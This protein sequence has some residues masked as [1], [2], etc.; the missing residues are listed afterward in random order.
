MKYFIDTEFDGYKGDLISMALIREDGEARYWV[1]QNVDIKNEWVLEH[2]EPH[3]FK[4][5]YEL[6]ASQA[7]LSREIARFMK[8][9]EDITILADWPDD[10]K[11]FC[12][13]I[14]FGPGKCRNLKK[15]KFEFDRNMGDYVS[16]VPHNA[17]YDA[18]AISEK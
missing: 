2:V 16:L 17:Y 14:V 1:I 12:D 18:K 9:D 4:G 7:D 13:T 6:V 11:Y 3:L 5:P 10:I 15:I 8:H